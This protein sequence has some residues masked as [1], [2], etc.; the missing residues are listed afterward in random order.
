MSEPKVR[1]GPL[2][3]V[4]KK[5]AYSSSLFANRYATS[6]SAPN[7]C[8]ASLEALDS[9]S[10]SI[11]DT[12][13]LGEVSPR[14]LCGSA[15][16]KIV[17]AQKKK[18]RAPLKKLVICP[19]MRFARYLELCLEGLHL[20]SLKGTTSRVAKMRR[21]SRDNNWIEGGACMMM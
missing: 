7:W 4:G 12:G 2:S 10:R 18:I 15:Q 8:L 20:Y 17:H 3:D 14:E 5:T 16:T 9:F 19:C 1:G 11:V 21:L 6:T 13:A